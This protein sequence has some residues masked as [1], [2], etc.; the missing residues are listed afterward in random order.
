M[1]DAVID[2]DFLISEGVALAAAVLL[3]ALLRA[4]LPAD[5]RERLR[6]PIG[7]LIL[8][9]V[10][11]GLMT[12][13]DADGRLADLTASAALFTL[14]AA[15]GRAGFLLV[16]DCLL[17]PK[18]VRPLPKIFR[19]ILQALVYIAV[20]LIT[21]RS[22]GVDPGSL[23]TTSALLTAI[24]GLSL[25]DTLGN[26]IAGLA[27]Q[28]E[29]PF[30]VGDWIHFGDDPNHVGRVLEIN[31]RATKLLTL[32]DVLLVVPNGALAKA[33][34]ANY[35]K[36]T[37]SVI[38]TVEVIA[39]TDTP[40]QR[41]HGL[42]IAAIEGVAGVLVDPPPTVL[43]RGFSERGVT[44][45]LR[46]FINDYAARL[47][48]ESAVR[49]RVW[50]AMHRAGVAIPPPQRAVHLWEQS[51][52]EDARHAQEQRQSHRQALQ[53]LDLLAALPAEHLDRLAEL[54]HTRLFAAGETI[55]HQGDVGDELF[56]IQRGEVAICVDSS[57]GALVELTRLGPGKFFGE[58]SIL[59]DS[60]R[61]ATVRAL[62]ECELLVVQKQALQQI[63]E[64]SPRLAE[65]I[66]SALQDRRE[67]LK[68]LS[69]EAD[70]IPDE[71]VRAPQGQL[72]GRIRDFFSL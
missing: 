58:M 54:V 25:Q 40:P 28:A 26:L 51:A 69:E 39:P 23:L 11:V 21:L 1:F 63:L 56:I 71:S 59:T 53:A 65:I 20:F 57:R 66:Q 24:I 14:L 9:L 13:A 44:Y 12:L 17:G 34:L 5:Q 31:W 42:L 3:L 64:R 60:R 61:H 36:P 2:R 72:L 29:T 62:A 16:M 4:W 6:L 8:H 45:A 68:Q 47:A 38:R 19:E 52:S 49:D 37:T 33:P 43:T 10:L 41:L 7:L 32:E 27:I 30:E 18:I 48:I 35:T 50:Y 67:L 70:R 46:Y 15:F 55:F 22:S